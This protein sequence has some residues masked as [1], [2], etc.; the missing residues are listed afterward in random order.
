MEYTITN[1]NTVV[2]KEI[3]IPKTHLEKL[4]KFITTFTS[5]KSN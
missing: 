2:S 4:K 5:N 3:N 1:K